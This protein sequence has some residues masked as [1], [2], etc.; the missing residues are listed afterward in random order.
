MNYETVIGLEIHVELATESKVFC[1]CTTEFG[2]ETN[3]HCCPVCTGMPGTLPAINEKAVEFAVKAGLAL[4]CEISMFSKMDRK[5]YFYPDLPK[6]YQISQFDLPL[7]KNGHVEVETEDGVSRIGI[8]RIHLEEDAGKLIHGPKGALVDYNRCGVPL[9]EIVSEPD[10]R[11][12]AQARAYF[13]K[14]HSIMQ[15][16][17]VSDGRMQE[18]SMRADVNLSLR[19]AGRDRFGTRT[20][21]KNLNSFRSVFNA[22]ESEIRRQTAVLENGK[23]VIQE[24]RRWDDDAG[25]SF[26]MRTKEEAHDYRYFPEPDIVPIVL[27]EKRIIE[28]GDSIPELPED[29]V[30]RYVGE[31]G[32][33]VYDAKVITASVKT[34]D[35]FEEAV[36]AGADPKTA[37]NW[38]MGDFMRM[39]NDGDTREIPFSGKLIS[40]LIGLVEKGTITAGI[41]KTVLAEMFA[42]GKN[43]SEIITEKGLEVVSDEGELEKIVDKAI[44]ENPK[45]VEDFLAGKNKALGF[46]MGRVMRETGGKA[47]PGKAR[48]MLSRKLEKLK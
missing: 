20:E 47:D 44:S 45:S 48:R 17:G 42:S 1:S 15:Y 26:S 30:D 2:G 34:A 12:P 22:A 37:S 40:E 43:P 10:M 28:I 38:I 29:R 3:T 27:D 39:M 21:M 18:G 35:F 41:G 23:K 11:T 46:L 32:I 19:P 36:N 13:E 24:T 16:I 6:A 8:T 33:P 7:C 9:I 25:K 4:N 14:I 31:L 5:N